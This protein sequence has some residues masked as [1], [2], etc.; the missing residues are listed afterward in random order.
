LKGKKVKIIIADSS[1]VYRTQIRNALVDTPWI[2]VQGVAS[3][4]RLALDRV[5]HH[6]SDLLILDLEMPDMSGVETL[7]E[8][9][10]RNLPCKV[11]VFSSVSAHERGI[12][13]EALV[14]GG[15]DYVLKPETD[16]KGILQVANPA[17]LLKN[18]LVPK[19]AQ[20]FSHII[21]KPNREAK[22]PP[23][24]Q[25]AFPTVNIDRTFHPEII[26][27]GS[28]TGGPTVLEKIFSE[29]RG[30]IECP[31]VI[32]QH[33]PPGFTKTFAERLEQLSGIPSREAIHGETLQ[34][35]RMYLAPGDYHLRL[36]SQRGQVSLLLDQEALV[37]SVRPSVDLLFESASS[38]YGNKCLALV[39]T[40][41]GADGKDGAIQVKNR[42]GGVVIQSE[43]SCVV[44]GMPGAVYLAGAYDKIA[45]PVE[46]IELLK[47]K[48]GFKKS[49]NGMAS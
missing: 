31:I 32:V 2:E 39:L 14:A 12:T 20:L 18:I 42:G 37:N 28:S 22:L 16:G 11:L 46:I 6:H 34:S 24:K 23:A 29:V 47:E 7:K 27:I 3:G 38:I 10:A 4:G 30:P 25:S 26:I 36:H 17:E 49:G 9:R 8:V 43:D 1:V 21:D 19:I 35:N 48:T 45:N 13:N 33:M 41:M 15:S 44:F 40:G 5:A